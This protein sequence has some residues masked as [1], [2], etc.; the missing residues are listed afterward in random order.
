MS[1]EKQGFEGRVMW[2]NTPQSRENPC[3][4]NCTGA[5]IVRLL[6][7]T[8]IYRTYVDSTLEGCG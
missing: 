3:K 7:D 4:R 8:W 6:E 5:A 2:Y 1:G